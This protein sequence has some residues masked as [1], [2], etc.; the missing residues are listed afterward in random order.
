MRDG[1]PYEA[2]YQ[3][4]GQEVL[5]S[6][7]KVQVVFQAQ[8]AGYAYLINEGVG[9][10]GKPG[11]F[12]LFPTPNI[13]GGSSSVNASQPIET[14]QN[15]LSGGKGTEVVWMIWTREKRDDLE[16]MVKN[17]FSL[18]GAVSSDDGA[19][20]K[21]LLDKNKDATREVTKDTANQQT[22]IKSNADIVVHRFEI[23]HR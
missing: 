10:D 14:A 1:K 22:V 17:A 11:Y 20:L 15:T 16:G 8:E 21:D 6:G 9:E 7:Y 3:T 13:N 2:P 18:R 5:E 23:E 4:S 19:K 12:L